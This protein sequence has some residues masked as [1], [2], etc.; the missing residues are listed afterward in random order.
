MLLSSRPERLARWKE[1]FHDLLNVNTSVN[2]DSTGLTAVTVN[3]D[4][5]KLSVFAETLAAVSSLKHNKATGPDGI[6]AEI[7]QSVSHAALRSM[8]EHICQVW[9]GLVPV[10]DEWKASY[11]VPLPKKGDLTKCEKWRGILLTAVPSKVFAR[12]VTGRLVRHFE[13]NQILPETQCGFQAG[14]GTADMIF[15]LGMALEVARAKH[16]PLYALF[17][18][19]MKA[20]DSV[21]RAGMWQIMQRKGVPDHLVFLVSNSTKVNRRKFFPKVFF[22]RHL[23]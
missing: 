5:Q 2:A 23:S 17:I 4:L 9:Q 21:S 12:I 1:H 22:L 15:T 10:P 11:L 7:L 16:I 18:D 6:S 19:L 13:Q 20:Y 14:R 8:H 3:L